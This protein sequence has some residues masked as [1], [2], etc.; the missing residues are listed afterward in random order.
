MDQVCAG[1][2]DSLGWQ[3]FQNRIPSKENLRQK[4]TEAGLR[5]IWFAC[6]WSIWKARNAKIFQAGE[7]FSMKKQRC[8]HCIAEFYYAETVYNAVEQEANFQLK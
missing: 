7:I 3:A 8:V 1:K 5:S 6:M 4:G 2:G